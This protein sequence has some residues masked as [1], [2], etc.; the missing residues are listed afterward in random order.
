VR[1]VYAGLVLIHFAVLYPDLAHWFS[2]EGVL[3]Y[4]MSREVVS[5]HTWTLLAWLPDTPA[6]VHM[7][8]WIAVGHAAALLVGVLPRVNAFFLFLWIVSFQVRN[9]IIHDG[10]DNLM[11]LM[12]FF[13]IWLPS[14]RCWSANSLLRRWW[15]GQEQGECLAPG[16]PLRLLQIEMAA[17]FFSSGLLKL[18]GEAWLNGTAMYYVSRLTD[19]FG[20]F[21]APA[22][23][24]DT[25][26]A[27]AAITWSVLA[28]ELVIPLLLWFRE[29]RPMCLVVVLLF[30]LA[31]EWTMNLFLFHWLML[32]GWIAFIQ[33]ADLTPLSRLWQSRKSTRPG[34]LAG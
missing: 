10:E 15:W 24:F 34:Q 2:C 13:M 22:W 16:W 32:C 23:L 5:V 11:R 33:P 6:A 25:P 4:E 29:T 8:F 26:W 18:S 30:H 14:G 19:F 31:N 21:P 27:V 1:I 17:M 20:R 9:S 28:A 7:A 3:P 12:A